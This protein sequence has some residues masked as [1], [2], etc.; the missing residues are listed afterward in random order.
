MRDFLTYSKRGI[1]AQAWQT[2]TLVLRLAKPERL[3]QLL[4]MIVLPSYKIFALFFSGVLLC[5]FCNLF[6]EFGY[7]PLYFNCKA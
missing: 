5:K 6:C 7:S 4:L 3:A 2:L 1:Y